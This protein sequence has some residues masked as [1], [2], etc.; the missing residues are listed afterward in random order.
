MICGGRKTNR[1]ECLK[2]ADCKSISAFP[3]QLPNTKCGKGAL[4]NNGILTFGD[5]I[6]ET[7]L[8]PRLKVTKHLSYENNLKLSGYGVACV[9][10]NA[11]VVVGGLSTYKDGR[12]TTTKR[13][14]IVR[15]YIPT[16]K[17]TKTL[18]PLPYEL[19]DMTVV[20]HEDSVIILGGA[21]GNYEEI[22]ND[23]LMYNIT[24]QHCLKLPSMLEKR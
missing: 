24:N 13:R 17:T 3:A 9:N 21:K 11:V 8:R 12:C 16:T 14:N 6:T 23:V 18:A 22:T 5:S 19:C 10:Q 7:T 15:L 4:C 2:V 20:A 1:I